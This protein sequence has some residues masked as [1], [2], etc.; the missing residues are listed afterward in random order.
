MFTFRNHFF[1]FALKKSHV[2]CTGF[3]QKSDIFTRVPHKYSELEYNLNRQSI[4]LTY[5]SFF[6]EIYEHDYI[7]DDYV[8]DDY[9]NDN[10]NTEFKARRLLSRSDFNVITLCLRDLKQDPATY[11]IFYCCINKYM[12]QIQHKS[13]KTGRHAQ[14]V[15]PNFCYQTNSL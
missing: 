9:D 13:L 14:C 8:I 6:K 15:V 5:N 7:H 3:P 10:Y 1:I 4:S 2:Y 11:T 12:N